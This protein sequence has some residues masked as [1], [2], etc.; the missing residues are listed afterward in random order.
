MKKNYLLAI[1][2]FLFYTQSYSQG[3]FENSQDTKT[4]DMSYQ[5]NGYV[6]GTYYAG[7]LLSNSQWGT[8]SAYGEAMLKLNAKKGDFG[9]A[10]TEFRIRNGVEYESDFTIIDLRE[11]YVSLYPGKFD[12]RLGKQIIVW[13][14]ADGVNPTNNITPQNLFSRSPNDDDTREG[15]FLLRTQYNIKSFN[16][17][18]IWLPTYKASVIPLEYISFGDNTLI[19]E[20]ENPNLEIENS[21]FALKLNLQKSAYDASVSYFNGYNPYQGIRSELSVINQDSVQIY[22]HKKA[23]RLHIFGGDFS[24][25]VGS[26]GLRGELAYRYP[27]EDYSKNAYVPNPDFQYILGI[28]RDFGKFDIVLQ[29][30]GRYVQD[31]TELQKPTNPQYYMDYY[32]EL[33]N[34]IFSGQLNEFSHSVS[35]RGNIDLLFETLKIELL[36]MYNFTTSE[37]MLRPKLTYDVYDALSLSVGADYY[38]GDENTMFGLT[39]PLL[40]CIFVELKTS[41]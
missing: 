27:F 11:A 25:T 40:N 24:T 6:R 5:L 37:I 20:D 34:R 19:G 12:I 16:L 32:S 2:L 17:E 13:G 33:N 8:Q 39:S 36:G 9:E 26:Y 15:N 18:F 10:F 41:F 21:A 28:D 29:Y 22:L 7:E 35:A 30:V 1:L 14:K 31:F 3:L 4:T 38:Y 23:F